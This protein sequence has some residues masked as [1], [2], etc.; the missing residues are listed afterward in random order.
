MADTLTTYQGRGPEGDFSIDL[1]AWATEA[2]QAKVLK[3]LDNMNKN[4]S[5]LPKNMGN[6]LKE[7]LKGNVVALK[8]LNTQTKK[9][10]QQQQKKTESDKKH[11]NKTQKAQD[12][13]VNQMFN[14][15]QA[16]KDIEDLTKKNGAAGGGSLADLAGKA[17]PLSIT[18]NLLSK[19]T[20]GLI[21]VFKGLFAA[22]TTVTAL[23]GRQFFKV[24][25]MLNDGLTEGT[26]R[27][28][29]A[30]TDAPVN[31]ATEAAKAGLSVREFGEALARNAEEI[32]TLGTENFRK[33]RNQI[34]DMEGG[35]FDMGFTQEQITNM[36]GREMSIRVRLG[37]QLDE[38]GRDLGVNIRQVAQE[39]R[40]LGNAAGIN[41]DILYDAGKQTDE[42]NALIAARARQFG[43]VGINA[44]STSVRT[45]AMR[46]TALSPNFGQ[47][48]S[49]PLI[50][51]MMAGAVGLDSAFT[52]LVTVMPG[53]VD[54]F[55]QGRDEIMR[56]N[57]IQ[58]STIDTMIERLAGVSEEEFNRAKMLALMTRNQNAINLVNFASEARARKDLIK[59]INA[60]GNV[61]AGNTISS[62]ARISSQLD[63]FIDAIK[64]P[65]ENAATIFAASFLGTNLEGG[66]AN[67]G[68]L[69]TAFAEQAQLFVSKIPI[70]RN[71][72]DNEF[73]DSLKA[74]TDVMFNE[75]DSEGKKITEDMREKARAG[76]NALITDTLTAFGDEMA[77][78]L[79]EGQ[80]GTYIANMFT[81]LIDQIAISVYEATGGKFMNEAAGRAF[82]RQGDFV[83]AQ[84]TGGFFSDDIGEQVLKQIME[85]KEQ[86]LK[87][88]GVE[89]RFVA[90]ELLTQY[91]RDNKTTANMRDYEQRAFE[92][93]FGGMT[94][95]QLIDFYNNYHKM[96]IMTHQL[97]NATGYDPDGPLN[98]DQV[99]KD[100]KDGADGIYEFLTAFYDPEFQSQ[101]KDAKEV[102]LLRTNEID[103]LVV[104]SRDKKFLQVKNERGVLVDSDQTVRGDNMYV[105]TQRTF[106]NLLPS[107]LRATDDRIDPFARARTETFLND[108]AFREM[109]KIQ[110][111]DTQAVTREEFLKFM[112]INAE[113]EF[114]GRGRLDELLTQLQLSKEEND[115]LREEFRKF[116]N[117]L[118][119]DNL[120]VNPN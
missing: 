25:N 103:P 4:F 47:E 91:F 44:L 96:S 19:A 97:M 2:T 110:E 23:I 107:I 7:A 18:M 104:P 12:A 69:I 51:A 32:I 106:N 49:Q 27:L 65:F 99:Q 15:A 82:V 68:T 5:N 87:N 20:G 40:M 31:L 113:G 41:A 66:G 50:N 52:D 45:L 120:L 48:V 71:L 33:L 67:L 73:F 24:F 81:Q 79:K 94:N 119:K 62:A 61:G 78:A 88:T 111:G 76:M 36:L 98:A 70:I 10:S 14:N 1:P 89:K 115:K 95:Q 75:K 63:I 30:F 3:Q 77:S 84:E 58:E 116:L 117:T 86:F 6:A 43:N 85:P 56:G 28:V 100:L 46:I 60:S 39:V 74:F 34:V 101:L 109:L 8:D 13:L 112:G 92:E 35:L 102:M 93:E 90:G 83:K 64:A 53:L 55:Q 38:S 105:G 80:L 59:N 118:N 21:S 42:T 54:V 17:G 22:V 29:G 114:T 57:G 26:G 9:Q 37:A 16:L 72:L 108:P 11:Q